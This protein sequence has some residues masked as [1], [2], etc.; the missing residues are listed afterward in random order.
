M[1]AD[2]TESPQ[3]SQS[4]RFESPVSSRFKL[5]LTRTRKFAGK[6]IASAVLQQRQALRV[7]ENDVDVTPKLLTHP[8]YSSIDEKQIT[9]FETMGLSQISSVGTLSLISSLNFAK[10]S[11]SVIVRTSSILSDSMTDDTL[12]ESLLSTQTDE[13]VFEDEDT[14]PPQFYLPRE[15]PNIFPTRPDTVTLTL[16]ETETFFIFEM[17]PR[18]ADLLTS[19]GVA[20]KQENENYEYKTIGPGSTRKLVDA[21]TQTIQVLMRSRGTYLSRKSRRNRGMFVNNWEMYDTYHAPE[22][23]LERN[24]LLVVHRKESIQE[25][26][27]AMTLKTKLPKPETYVKKTDLEEQIYIFQ[28]INF[29]NAVQIMERIISNNIFINAQKRFTGLIKQ[30][31]CSLDLE[32]TYSPDLLWIHDCK[33]ASG[34][35]VSSFCWNYVNRNI[36]AVGYGARDNSDIKDGLVLLWSA[37]NPGVPA[38]WYTFNSPVSDLD[39]SRERPNLLAIGYYNGEIKV[40]DVSNPDLNVVRR[41]EKATSSS[42]SPHWQVQWWP[43]DEQYEYQEQIYTCNQD[44]CVFCYRY[45]E[46]FTSS[47]IMKIYRIEGTL[48]G[49]TRTVPCNQYHTSINR[50]P[51]ALVLRKHPTLSTIY[52]VGTDE[53]CIYKCSTN[54]LYQHID[55]FLAHDGP[56]YSMMFSPFCPKIFLTCGADWCIR[57]WAENLTEPLITLSTT[58]AC[59]RYAAWSP[60]HS[61]IIVSIV[62][63]EICIWD[64]RRKTYKPASVTISPNSD[65][66]VM[67]DFTANGNQ[68]VV[69]DVKG[70]VYVYNLE[71]MPFPPYNQQ[72]VLVDSIEKA[73]ITKPILLKNLKKLGSPFS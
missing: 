5:S 14:A 13:F 68:L 66:F 16:R 58:M 56:V 15:D 1:K 38:R 33:E 73:L 61:T 71:G 27:D 32:F 9:A 72:Q 31:L 4:S 59:V 17:Q 44:G 12:F 26:L 45:V 64:I 18:T 28:H 36:V 69:A 52:F 22:L 35:L 25:M 3:R 67:V 60:I 55:S 37:K 19:E 46:D 7:I 57:I 2:A 49:V 53:G 29:R 20:V 47:T 30:D 39:W 41:S 6:N 50:S 51:G 21:E 48:P 70:V 23:M 11:S 63:N 24:G 43:G 62:N 40:I 42:T 10:R 34:R 65:R 54:Y 8:T